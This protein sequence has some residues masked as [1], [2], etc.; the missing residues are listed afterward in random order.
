MLEAKIVLVASAVA[1]GV[2]L[3]ASPA[4]A[5]VAPSRGKC[6]VTA[7]DGGRTGD[8]LAALGLGLIGATVIRRR[9]TR[10]AR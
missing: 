4:A 8:R 6:S 7:A 3:L 5:D 2:T 10:A 1:L 9:A